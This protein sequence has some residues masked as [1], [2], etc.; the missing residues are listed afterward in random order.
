M[1]LTEEAETENCGVHNVQSNTDGLI[2]K[3]VF[4]KC[5]I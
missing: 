5:Q 2:I 3:N 1:E 4:V